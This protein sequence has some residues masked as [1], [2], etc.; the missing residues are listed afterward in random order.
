MV[1]CRTRVKVK[2]A[3]LW[4]VTLYIMLCNGGKEQYSKRVRALRFP[5]H[6][7]ISDSPFV[8]LK[9][10]LKS[11]EPCGFNEVPGCHYT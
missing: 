6:V 5:M 3:F 11:W 7:E 10:I 2:T 8:P 9:L 4:N 1:S